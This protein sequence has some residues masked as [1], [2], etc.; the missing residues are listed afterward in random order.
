MTLNKSET[1]TRVVRS[2]VWSAGAGCHGGCG[3]EL[4]VRDGK[5]L[6]VEGDR[7]H[8]Y[9][10]GS[11]CPRALALKELMYHKD[12]LLFPLKRMGAR[13]S[14]TWQRIS[15]DEAYELIET[16]MKAL[17]DKHGAESA[18]FV[19]GTGRDVG[20]WLVF[21]AYNYGSP[22]WIQS[23]PGNSCYH[24]RLVSMKITMGDYVA[25]DNS[26]FWE[27]RYDDPRWQLPKVYMVW[28]QNPVAT[29][30]DGSHGH[31]IIHC[32][33]RGSELIVIDPVYTWLASRAKLWLQIRPGTDGALALGMLNVIISEGLYNREF[34]EKW[35]YGFDELKERVGEY[36][37]ERVAEI[38]WVQQEKI[39]QAA[40]MYASSKPAALQWGVPIDFAP[41]GLTVATAI[42]Y[43]WAITGNVDNPG[44]M[45]I[46]RNAF[47]ITPYPMSQESIRAMYGYMMPEAQYAKKIGSDR[48]PITRDFHWRAHADSVVDQMLSGKP[49][50]LKSRWTAGTNPLIGASDPKRWLEAFSAM[51]FNVVVDVFMTPSAQAWADVVLPAAT[52]PEREGIRAWWTPLC[53]QEKAATVGECK[54]D[55][56]I[57]FE[58]G[59]RFNA[60]FRY[61]S[62]EDLYRSYLKGSGITLEES[63][64]KRWMLPPEG[65]RSAP[66][67]RHE[68]GLLRPDGKPGFNTPTGKVELCSTVYAKWGYDPLPS[69]T[70]PTFSPLSRPDLAKDYPLVLSTGARTVAFFHSEHRQIDSMRRIEP[71]PR[72]RIHPNTAKPLNIGDGDWVWVE[73][74]HG[75]CRMKARLTTTLDPRVVEAP[76]SWWFPEKGPETWYGAWDAN[77]NLLIPSGLY[78]KSGFGG[79]QMK[80]LLCRVYRA[81]SGIEGLR[82]EGWQ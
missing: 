70:E 33:K 66:Y 25:P 21:L 36:P 51:E 52:F 67:F 11:L 48:F 49:Y 14:N 79:S 78:S 34:V 42:S 45:V 30:N 6:K 50:P 12:R 31:W 26:Q 38:T 35:T 27:Q 20:G 72:L 43:L 65:S 37:V 77:V 8:P 28:G 55:A 69:Y 40:R 3:V 23:L 61:E 81:E 18:V 15:W 9:N 13:G 56:E 16:R 57:A 58:L 24:P 7:A 80:S 1:G 73:S 47:G 62:M 75:R 5:L 39:V 54:S 60:N 64:E 32:M 44:G 10:M 59:R 74:P 19:Q 82:E 46:L 2:M 71:V 17:R 63:K 76:H 41:E 29:C 53:Y 22:N 68:K 4:H